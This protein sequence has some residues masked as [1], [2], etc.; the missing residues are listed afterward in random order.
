M[1]KNKGRLTYYLEII[2]KKYYFVKKI[3]SYSK[4]Y[5]EGKTKT[6]KRTLSELVFN[7]S[8]VGAIDFTKNGLRPVDKNILLTMMKECKESDT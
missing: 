4:E 2:D 3:S 1:R 7:E 8:E 6:T 5:T